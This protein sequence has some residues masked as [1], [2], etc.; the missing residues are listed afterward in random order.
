M[1]RYTSGQSTEIFILASL[2]ISRGSNPPRSTSL[3][4]RHYKQLVG[5]IS[6]FGYSATGKK[7]GVSDNAIRKWIKFYEKYEL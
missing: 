1:L 6:L 7:Y 2:V 3:I 4:I 5:E